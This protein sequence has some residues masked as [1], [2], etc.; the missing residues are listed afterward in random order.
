MQ[1]GGVAGESHA[2]FD[3]FQTSG[4]FRQYAERFVNPAQFNEVNPED[5]VFASAPKRYGAPMLS[6]ERRHGDPL[7]ALIVLA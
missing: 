1:A 6:S 3:L 5:Y 7:S 4:A 2:A